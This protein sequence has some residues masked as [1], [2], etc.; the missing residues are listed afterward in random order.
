MQMQGGLGKGGKDQDS[1]NTG[2]AGT[3]ELQIKTDGPGTLRG[4]Q[5]ALRAGG[6]P[7]TKAEDRAGDPESRVRSP[8]VS[9]TLK[10]AREEPCDQ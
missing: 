10:P 6:T 1:L 7:L 3:A 5:G 4:T 2:S 8:R 9:A